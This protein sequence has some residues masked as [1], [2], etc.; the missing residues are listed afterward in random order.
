[1]NKT[2]YLKIEQANETKKTSVTIGDIAKME[3]SEQFILNRLKTEKLFSMDS[4]KNSRRIVS[5]LYVIQKIHEI[6][7]ELEV[8][9]LGETDFVVSY[10]PKKQPAI[11][12]KCKIA[13]VCAMSFFGSM[14]AMMTFNED[15]STHESFVKVYEWVMGYEPNGV[16]VLEITYSIGVSV[17]IIIFFN[18]LGKKYLTDDPSPVEVE[19]AGYEQQVNQSLIKQVGRRGKEKDVD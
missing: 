10:R 18:H 5:V 9:N 4:G 17:G 16:T 14:F 19:M 7:P 3:C 12:E 11:W 1:M 8:Q 13:F 15:V 2:L 6:Y